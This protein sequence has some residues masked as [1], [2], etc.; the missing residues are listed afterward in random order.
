MLEDIQGLNVDNPNDDSSAICQRFPFQDRDALKTSLRSEITSRVSA[1]MVD[2][3]GTL[4]SNQVSPEEA[5]WPKG[6]ERDGNWWNMVTV[7]YYVLYLAVHNY[8]ILLYRTVLG[9]PA[10]SLCAFS[11]RQ[12]SLQCRLIGNTQGSR[13][14]LF[15]LLVS[16]HNFYF[17]A[18]NGGK[19]GKAPTLFNLPRKH[20]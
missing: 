6:M 15:T 2:A 10:C 18:F 11:G 3:L 7:T 8:S 1:R 4:E 5:E 13:Q 20:S 17:K 16:P 19:D 9:C 12:A 14:D